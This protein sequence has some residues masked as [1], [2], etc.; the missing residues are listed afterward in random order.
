ME[1]PGYVI[2]RQIGQGGMATAY[3]AE[4][5][6]LGRQVVLKVLDSKVRD[7]PETVERFL[8]EGRII[9]SLNH[10]HIITIYD[11]GRSDKHVYISMEYIEGGDLRSRMQRKV[12]APVEAIDVIEKIASGLAAAHEQGI[13][14]RDVKPGNILFRSDGTPLLSDFGIA[15]RLSGDRDLTSTGMFLGSPN[16]MAPEQSEAGPIDGRADIYALGVIFYEML[17]GERAYSADS[18]IDV[19]VMHKKA[20]VPR[21][22]AGFEQYQELLNLMMAKN[23]KER[24]RDARALLH[25]IA[26]MRK[27]GVIK[28]KADMTASPDI[29]ITGEHEALENTPP[30]SRVVTLER[31]RPPLFRLVMLGMLV[32][33]GIGWGALLTIER[34]IDGPAAPQARVVESLDSIV[35]EP[36]PAVAN[37]ASASP[38][39]R[40]EV[41]EALLWLGHHSIDELRLT[42]PA[43]DNAYYYFS[44]LLQIDPGNQQAREGLKEI[45]ARF[46]FLAEREIASERFAQARSYIRM[47]SQIDPHN[48]SLQMLGD[49]ASQPEIGFWGALA[50][51]FR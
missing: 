42:A 23:R 17:S 33:C 22:P 29:D 41:A 19:I 4:Q 40:R 43:R 45:A 35:V 32:L 26:E 11:I 25:F 27:A 18:V 5:A 16:Y 1:I 48:E 28:S 21:L 2:K 3:L 46:A 12:F 9:A 7:A 49:V 34:R 31:P 37:G 38:A 44:R 39:E 13:V 50:S 15:K 14:H 47:G 6:S 10:P 24:F 20:P 30:P 51:L 8:N 36:L